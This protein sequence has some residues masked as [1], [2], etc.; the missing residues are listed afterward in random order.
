MVDY[1]YGPLL[2]SNHYS[3]HS[4]KHT[5]SLETITTV[6]GTSHL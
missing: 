1:V 6:Q 3:N 5:T 2:N 4:I